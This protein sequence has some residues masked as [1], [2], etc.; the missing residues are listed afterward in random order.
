MI[1]ERAL[2]FL[3]LNK[4]VDTITAVCIESNTDISNVDHFEIDGKQVN[5]KAILNRHQ[6]IFNEIL[7]PYVI[8]TSSNED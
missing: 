3:C 8:D 2:E 6:E 7:E 5:F 4:V 1:N